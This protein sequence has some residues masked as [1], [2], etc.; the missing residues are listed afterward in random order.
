MTKEEILNFLNPPN[1]VKYTIIG[2]GT[3]GVKY[4]TELYYEPSI[5][6]LEAINLFVKNYSSKQFEGSIRVYRGSISQTEN[7]HKKIYELPL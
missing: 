2:D 4:I 5:S 7:N 1:K 3:D 6:P